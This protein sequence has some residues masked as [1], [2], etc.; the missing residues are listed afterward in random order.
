MSEFCYLIKTGNQGW[1]QILWLWLAIAAS[2]HVDNLVL[3]MNLKLSLIPV[4]HDSIDNSSGTGEKNAKMTGTSH[5]PE[6]KIYLFADIFCTHLQKNSI[7]DI[8]DRR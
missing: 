3:T 4:M 7:G 2:M 6:S 5:L 8:G 1:P